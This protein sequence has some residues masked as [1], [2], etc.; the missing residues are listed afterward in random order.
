MSPGELHG[1]RVEIIDCCLEGKRIL[2][3]GAILLKPPVLLSLQ[4]NV[5]AKNGG[6]R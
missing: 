4:P 5:S 3:K 1:D 6:D 2:T